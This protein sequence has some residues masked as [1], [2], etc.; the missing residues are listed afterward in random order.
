MNNN[1]SIQEMA[2][3][4]EELI[5]N[6]NKEKYSYINISQKDNQGNELFRQKIVQN[7]L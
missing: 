5:K 3:K 2:S 1:T 4:R 7:L 6:I